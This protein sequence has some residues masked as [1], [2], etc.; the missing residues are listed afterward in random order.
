[1]QRTIRTTPSRSRQISICATALGMDGEQFIQLAISTA[2]ITLGQEDPLVRLMLLRAAGVDWSELEAIVKQA[3]E[4]ADAL[5]A[6]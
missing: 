5:F 4:S 2:I 3:R 1:M 6:G